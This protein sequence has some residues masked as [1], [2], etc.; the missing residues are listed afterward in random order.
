MQ[1][2]DEGHLGSVYNDLWSDPRRIKRAGDDLTLGWHFGYYEVGIH[3]SKQA[4]HNMDAYVGRLLDLRD[5]PATVLDAG[6]GVGGTVVH[7]AKEHPASQFY[8][9]TLGASE[10]AHAISLQSRFHLSNTHFS[11]QSYNT[12]TFPDAFFDAAYALESHTHNGAD[13]AAFL[14]QMHRVLK[15]GGRLIN[16]DVFARSRNVSLAQAI[17][18]RILHEPHEGWQRTIYS[19]QQELASAGFTVTAVTD[20]SKQR[21]IKHL[22]IFALTLASLG[23]YTEARRQLKAKTKSTPAILTRFAVRYCVYALLYLM[24]HFGYFTIIAEKNS[25]EQ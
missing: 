11:Q 14:R 15:P 8:G 17:R 10:V 9:I 7:L 3:G 13:D 18:L 12:T 2:K 24:L 20:L 6:C 5:T 25:P 23:H 22:F 1:Y 19:F 21:H 16:L 4:M